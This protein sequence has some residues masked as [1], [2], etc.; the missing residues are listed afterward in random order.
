MR[1]KQLNGELR[2][3]ILDP[4]GVTEKKDAGIHAHAFFVGRTM[5]IHIPGHTH[6]DIS[7]AKADQE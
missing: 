1:A 2:R 6:C 4:A 3:R 5:F 7:L